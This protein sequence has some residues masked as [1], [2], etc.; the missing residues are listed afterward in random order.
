MTA[1]T[2][3]GKYE[4]DPTPLGQGAMGVVYRA[5]DPDLKQAV[6]IK[7]IRKELLEGAGEHHARERFKKEAIAGRR[8]RHPN[9]V[10]VYE[11]GEDG[12]RS[13]IV[14][15]LIEGRRLKDVLDG[16]QRFALRETLSVMEQMLEALDYAHRQHVVHRD[17]KPANLLY[18]E[19]GHLQVADFG[20]ARIDASTLTLTGAVLGT[21]GYMSPEQCQGA[22]SD[23]RADLFAAG[24]ILYE[25][26]S[27]ERPFRASWGSPSPTRY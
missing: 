5:F 15:A 25:L 13:Y 12:D 11:Y 6:A 7:V 19:E 27:G 8:L 1:L 22:P 9:I 3:L 14:M 21:P 10:P 16:G 18:S 17:I 24:V 2:Q 26:L 23:H 4:L 20:I